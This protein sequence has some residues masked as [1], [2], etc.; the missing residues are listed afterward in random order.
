MPILSLIEIGHIG[1]IMLYSDRQQDRQKE[2][3]KQLIRGFRIHLQELSK[4]FKYKSENPLLYM[5]QL[6]L[7]RVV[8]G[9]RHLV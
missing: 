5:V 1:Y 7:G 4:T 2:R 3:L 9:K 6:S 8:T